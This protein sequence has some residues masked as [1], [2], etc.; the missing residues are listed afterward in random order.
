MIAYFFIFLILWIK[1]INY[2]ATILMDKLVEW[3]GG[4]SINISTI[5][6]DAYILHL[7]NSET[8]CN[9]NGEF[10]LAICF[11]KKND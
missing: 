7:C 5:L 11:E 8:I 4:Y 9:W 3:V 2:D 6:E 10:S 1:C